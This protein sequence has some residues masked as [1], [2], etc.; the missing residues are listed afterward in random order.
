[1]AVLDYGRIMRAGDLDCSVQP[2][3]LT[4]QAAG[5]GHGFTVNSGS[6]STW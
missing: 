5:S 6:Y 1:M 4:C 3:G 2:D